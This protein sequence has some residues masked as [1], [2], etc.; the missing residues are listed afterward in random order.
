MV[1]RKRK[2]LA[3]QFIKECQDPELNFSK[4]ELEVIKKT[5]RVVL[6][7]NDSFWELSVEANYDED[8]LG[9]SPK[10]WGH[11]VWHKNEAEGKMEI[12]SGRYDTVCS[13]HDSYTCTRPQGT[14]YRKEFDTLIEFIKKARKA[15]VFRIKDYTD[16][17]ARTGDMS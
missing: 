7:N 5:A 15:E 10:L 4:K 13:I 11:F 8:V 6:Y 1:E 2:W 14:N 17:V 12:L 16:Y 9:G 3:K